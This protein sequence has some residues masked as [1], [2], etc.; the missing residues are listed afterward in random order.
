[1][2][3][4]TQSNY[5]QR[6]AG[7]PV[8]SFNTYG[9]AQAA[10]DRLSDEEFPVEELTIVGVD[11]IEVE[12][13]TGRLTWS[14]VL[15]SGALSGAWIGLFFGLLFGILGGPIGFALLWGI[16]LGV[17][18]GLIMAA[19]PY[20]FS[21]G[22]RDFTSQTQIVAGRYDILSS[23]KRAT[24]ARDLIA[25]KGLATNPSTEEEPGSTPGVVGE[26]PDN[27]S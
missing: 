27:N 13:V 16:I 22:Q 4:R 8:G 6:P 3:N 9:E 19:V 14:K 26:Q 20:A 23:P 5:R 2:S 7:W 15:L 24:E 12:D 18:F 1:M 17:I 21:G 25:K 11:L 10:V